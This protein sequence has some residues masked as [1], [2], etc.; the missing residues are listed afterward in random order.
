MVL[1]PVPAGVI[2]YDSPDPAGTPLVTSDVIVIA[3]VGLT[4]NSTVKLSA[5]ESNALP[6][7]LV[8]PLKSA[9]NPPGA[10][11]A[12]VNV[13]VAPGQTVEGLAL[14]VAAGITGVLTVVFAF[15]VQ[16]FMVTLTV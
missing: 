10:K 1:E 15:A 8:V 11:P 9:A 5:Y 14:I 6:I 3:A 4:Q 12:K 2:A 16:P 7:E 13:E